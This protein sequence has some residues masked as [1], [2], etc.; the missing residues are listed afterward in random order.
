M[1]FVCVNKLV[2]ILFGLVASVIDFL[3]GSAVAALAVRPCVAE[4]TIVDVA[5]HGVEAADTERAV[6]ILGTIDTAAREVGSQL[7]DGDAEHLLAQD[8]LDA[9]LAV[10]HPRLQPSVEPLDN[11][12][13]E[14]ARLR[15]RVEKG[16]GG[17][18]EQLLRQEVE[19]LIGQRRR[20]E[21]LVVAQIGQAVEHI[22]IVRITFHGHVF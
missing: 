15:H 3:G 8:M 6:G 20:R 19:H 2:G 21:H 1:W 14:H 22:G 13:E 7:G 4:R 12:A 11:L 9:L 5:T 10:G 16:S 17:R 18:R